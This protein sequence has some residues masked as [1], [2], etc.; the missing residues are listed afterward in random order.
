MKKRNI[1]T[2]C[3]AIVLAC[4]AIFSGCGRTNDGK[5]K[6]VDG[7]DDGRLQIVTTLYAPYDF[8]KQIVKDDA[9]VTMLLAPGEESHSYDPTPQDIIKIQ[10]CDIFI[11]N[12][13]ESEEWVEDIL[14][15]IPESVKTVKM[16]DCDCILIAEDHENEFDEHV[17]ASPKN[18]IKISEKITDAVIEKAKEKPD[19]T[20]EQIK[21][22][23]TNYYNFNIKLT[24]L[25][26]DFRKTVEGAKRKTLVFADRF[27]MRYFVNEYGLDYVAAFPG[28]SAD[29]EASPSVIAS[30]VDKVKTENIPIV[31]KMELGNGKLAETVS[32]E[33]GA[34]IET[35][36][37]CHNV[38]KDDFDNNVGYVDLMKHNLEVLKKALY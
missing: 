15:D 37:V 26:Q 35:F 8:A 17:W 19:Y 27:P 3:L 14:S 30:L 2:I 29:V 22:F 16:M 21:T 33:T 10:N 1:A 12:G 34:K 24:G 31:L 28:C 36:Y 18:A 6:N 11:Y 4:S 13:G 23:E 32:E 9:D 20:E 5:T 7:L 25:D 38:S